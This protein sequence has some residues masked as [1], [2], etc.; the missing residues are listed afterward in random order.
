MP[1]LVIF[2]RFDQS[3]YGTVA[4]SLSIFSFTAIKHLLIDDFAYKV[5]LLHKR[6]LRNKNAK[7]EMAVTETV[8]EGQPSL[9]K[10]KA[11]NRY[12]KPWLSNVPAISEEDS[13]GK[14]SSEGSPRGIIISEAILDGKKPMD[15]FSAE[16]TQPLE[17]QAVLINSMGDEETHPNSEWTIPPFLGLNSG[18]RQ[19]QIKKDP[20]GIRNIASQGSYSSGEESKA[21][22]RNV[23]YIRYK[24]NPESNSNLIIERDGQNLGDLNF[25]GPIQ[26]ISLNENKELEISFG[27]ILNNLSAFDN[28]LYDSKKIMKKE[29]VRVPL[30]GYDS[31]ESIEV[32][33]DIDWPRR[34]D[35]KQKSAERVKSNEKM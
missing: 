14:R 35:E 12:R 33:I 27:A 32:N 4:I 29:V 2:I 20:A 3:G 30:G 11:T 31:N 1:I 18:K 16:N 22:K 10:T 13:Q 28:K 19:L 5:R 25:S 8:I 34:S 7:V 26:N 23:H 21:S 24:Q 9:K 6:A 17:T 15:D